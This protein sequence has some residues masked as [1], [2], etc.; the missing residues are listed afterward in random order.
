[1]TLRVEAEMMASYRSRFAPG[2]GR[3]QQ[4]LTESHSAIALPGAESQ[5]ANEQMRLG[6][7]VRHVTRVFEAGYG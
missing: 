1:V 3:S 5:T 2:V 4:P 6:L 7:A